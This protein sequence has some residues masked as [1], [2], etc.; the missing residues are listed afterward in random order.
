MQQSGAERYGGGTRRR[1]NAILASLNAHR[2]TAYDTTETSNVYAENVAVA[3]AI[4]NAWATNARVGYLADPQRSG[5][6]PRWE[7]ILDLTPSPTATEGER[8][9][10]VI[11]QWLRWGTTP[12]MQAVLDEAAAALGPL[13]IALH[14]ET[15]ATATTWWPGGT[16]NPDAP[17]YST[18]A[19]ITF[20]V[21]QPATMSDGEFTDRLALLGPVLDGRLPSW[22]TWDWWTD[23]EDGTLG[24]I[25]D[26]EHNLDTEAFD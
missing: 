1:Y 11:K 14:H 17:W 6:I 2:G 24:F 12:T 10:A 9:R 3:R 21:A 16:P 25:L 26:D 4:D 22:V 7:R 23:N 13:F 18:I 19:H 20:E 15:V 8:R 5:D